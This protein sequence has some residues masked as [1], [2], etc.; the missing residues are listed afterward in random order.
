MDDFSLTPGQM[1]KGKLEQCPFGK[2]NHVLD[3]NQ[4][5]GDEKRW[6]AK[7]HLIGGIQYKEQAK[8][9]SLSVCTISRWV[10]AVRKGGILDRK[11]GR[12][13]VLDPK[14]HKALVGLLVDQKLNERLDD[15][16]LEVQKAVA[17]TA[18]DA[19]IAPCY[20][21][22]ISKRSMG[23][24]RIRTREPAPVRTAAKFCAKQSQIYR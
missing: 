8:R 15:W 20:V 5:A 2:G 7:A 10:Q 6:I 16:E 12:P 21:K 1:K 13:K 4:L 3:P 19:G 22:P 9:F 23:T 18:A 14:Y 24:S 17:A 11:G